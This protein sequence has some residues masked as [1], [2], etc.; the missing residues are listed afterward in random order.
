MY[1]LAKFISLNFLSI[2]LLSKRGSH[3]PRSDVVQ[4][5]HL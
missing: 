3:M 2:K 5:H 4:H 1:L